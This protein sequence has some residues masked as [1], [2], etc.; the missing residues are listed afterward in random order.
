MTRVLG[1]NRENG[2]GVGSMPAPE[3]RPG[4]GMCLQDGLSV[5]D[6]VQCKVG[7]GG[8]TPG[9]TPPTYKP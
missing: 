4:P 9:Q 2:R 3:S 6:R 1:G 8:R 7:G 5:E